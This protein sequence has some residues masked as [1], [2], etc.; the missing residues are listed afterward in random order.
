MSSLRHELGVTPRSVTALVDALEA[1]ALV[2][3]LPHPTDRR[4]TIVKLTDEGHRVISGR[5]DAHAD[6]AARVFARL[7]ERDQRELLRLL[8]QLSDALAEVQA[9]E[10]TVKGR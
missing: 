9:E 7:D 1:D 5:Y 6:R 2:C 4:A 8:R 3:R 10:R